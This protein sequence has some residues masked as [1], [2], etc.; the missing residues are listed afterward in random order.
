[1]DHNVVKVSMDYT[2]A[3]EKIGWKPTISVES[4]IEFLIK[5][6]KS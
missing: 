3:T 5:G 4:G 6:S 2:S 1:M